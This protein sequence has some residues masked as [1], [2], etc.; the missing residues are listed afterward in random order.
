MASRTDQLQAY[1]FMTQRVISALVMRETDPRQSPLR[2]GVGAV[3]GGLM[4]AI[5]VGAGFGIFGILTKVGSDG[6]KSNSSVVIEKESGASFVYLKG[7]LY[8]TLNLTSAML[9]S[10]RANPSV[11]RVSSGSLGAVPRGNTVGIPGAPASLPAAAKQVGLPWTVCVLPGADATTS[12]VALAVSLA[13]E[14]GRSL[15][16]EGVL[17]KDTKLGTTYLI[18]HSARHLVQSSKTLVPTL[19]GAAAVPVPVGT[20]WLNTVPLGADIGPITVSLAGTASTAVKGRTIGDILVAQTGSGPQNYVVFND[21][22]APITELQRFVLG[23][24]SRVK[25]IQ[26]DLSEVNAA[27]RSAR[28]ITTDG[29]QQ[30]PASAPPLARLDGG[31]QLCAVTGAASSPPTVWL[32][33]MAGLDEATPT[34][35]RSA[36]GAAL[37]DRILVPA[38][39]VAV[40]RVLGGPDAQSGPYF[41]VTDLGIKYPVSAEPVLAMLGYAPAQAI[42]VP[43]SLMARIPTGP[44]LD[45]AAAVV[46]AKVTK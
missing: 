4:I 39:R 38:G 44:T 32:G 1:Q 26:V 30:A 17:V 33:T 25:V 24:T 22:L 14:G 35:S 42:D 28:L 37:A 29:I 2:R 3:F 41:I 15:A 20:A 8:P 18:W 9:A 46:P 34:T 6:W 11:F 23:A 19:F 21:G 27:A 13:P 31:E 10:G 16:D 7:T 5:L 45:P 12:T 43:S 36:D 40:V